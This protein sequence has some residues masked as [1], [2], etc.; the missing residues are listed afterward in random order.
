[1]L[2]RFG[3]VD[4]E[5][6]GP[7][8][9]E[10]RARWPIDP[11][12][13]H[14]NHGSFGA[15]PT[16]VQREQDRL[17]ERTEADPTGFFW[18]F[19]PDALERARLEA[20]E[21]V[22][23]DPDGFVFLPNVTTAVNTVLARLDLGPG[24]EVLLS[25]HVYGALRLT[26]ERMAESTGATVVVNPVPLPTDG[27][28]QL[29]ASVLSGVTPRTKLALV[30]HI[31][32]PTAL[33]FPIAD[34]V[35]ELRDRR[36]LSLVDGA[37]VPGMVDID[38]GAMAPD[39]WTGNFHKWCCAPRGAAGFY[40]AE[41]HRDRMAPLVTSWESPKGFAPSYSW[42][43]TTD[44]TAYLCVS[45]ALSFMG[46]LGWERV[47]RH[48]RELARL[49]AGIVRDAIGVSPN[50]SE[51]EGLFEA[52]ALI[53]L[54]DGVV[55]TVDEGRALSRQMAEDHRIEVAAFPWRDRGFVRLSAQVYNAPAEYERLAQALGGF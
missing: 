16:Q 7:D 6:W 3:R 41:E 25:D 50:W 8:W 22:R 1:V 29:T 33:V 2:V 4:N 20:A 34:I 30:E 23:A 51:K 43:G 52:M 12:V 36:V 31:A 18:W 17:R 47:R 15:V 10:V 42:L 54:P 19:L 48:N 32:S 24:D 38:L 49:G 11:A 45:E 13:A 46:D 21:F 27:P 39:F 28:E 44:Y 55:T 53:P 14:L 26:A 35:S 40:V 37:H 5:L 9:A